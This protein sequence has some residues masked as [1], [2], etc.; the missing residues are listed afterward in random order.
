MATDTP[1]ADF[2]IDTHPEHPDVVVAAGFSGHGF[3]FVPVIADIA[4][5]LALGATAGEATRLAG[6]RFALR[7]WGAHP[8]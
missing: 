1:D 2:I 4:A 3:K 5:D 6:D 7:R 8:H